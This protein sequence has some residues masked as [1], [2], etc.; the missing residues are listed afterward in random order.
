M[1]EWLRSRGAGRVDEALAAEAAAAFPDCSARAMREA[2][3]RSGLDVAP[4][5]EGVRQ[6]NVEELERTLG[7]LAEEYAAAGVERRRQI[8]GLVITA[9][10]HAEWGSRNRKT[11]EAQRECR[12]EALL[13]IRTWLENPAVFGAWA[14]LRRRALGLAHEPTRRE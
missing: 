2:F 8:R 3:L 4:M 6:E 12:M 13:W 11:S 9:R 10:Q 5:V 7:A 14:G 1:H